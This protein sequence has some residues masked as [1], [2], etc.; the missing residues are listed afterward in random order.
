METYGYGNPVLQ[1]VVI[2]FVANADVTFSDEA[3][4]I[5]EAVTISSNCRVVVNG[6]E[7]FLST[8]RV[9]RRFD[10]YEFR[11]QS[12]IVDVFYNDQ[13]IYAQNLDV[14]GAVASIG[15][16]ARVDG[17]RVNAA[18]TDLTTI[19]Y[20]D[21]SPSVLSLAG[22]FIEVEANL[23]KNSVPLLRSFEFDFESAESVFP[24]RLFTPET[25]TAKFFDTATVAIIG[26]GHREETL[27]MQGSGE[28]DEGQPIDFNANNTPDGRHFRVTS[29]PIVINTLK[30]FLTHNAIERLL[31]ENVDYH[32]NLNNGY[33]VLFHP[34]A[35]GD[36]LRVTYTSEA[37]SNTPGLFTDIGDIITQFGTPSV[38]NT[39]SLGAQIA[40]ENG[41][42][43][44]LAVQALDPTIDA[45]WVRAYNTLT[46]EEAYFVVPIPPNNYPLVAGNGLDHVENQSS[47]P[48][49]GERILILGET[50]DLTS[51]DLSLFR[52]T[53]RTIFLRPG[54]LTRVVNGETALLDGRF[55]AAAY[56]G[57][58]SSLNLI[59][60]PMTGKELVGFDVDKQQKFTNIELENL[61]KD[62]ITMVRRLTAGGKVF[63]SVTTS[64]SLLA[65]EQEQ[66]L[67]RVRD[68]L[69]INIRKV[70]EDRF[71]GQAIISPQILEII[72]AE[73]KRFLEFQ[74]AQRLIAHYTSVRVKIDDLEPR[75]VNISFDVEPVF[76]LNNITL[77]VRVV[78]RV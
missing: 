16:G 72:A 23:R 12:G 58:F 51:A 31:L 62:G 75:Q 76:P 63:R 55:M 3:Q 11:V 44:I 46:K 30:V 28:E 24:S 69:A 32:T 22:R 57:K 27:V 73:T 17:D 53:F 14:D 40:F 60:E 21:T 59:S 68:F 41:A 48:R 18:F 61:A 37:D 65:V 54:T 45:G 7:K 36:H 39:L 77:T 10:N 71:V 49:R 43:R 64:N 74:I 34:I 1:K 42:K 9:T 15:A 13:P 47:T 5:A 29:F 52:D 38:E 25:V 67:V 50:D 66:S 70:L 19:H 20:L 35:L 78:T 33:V 6:E 2:T 8:D 26:T 4:V 56:A